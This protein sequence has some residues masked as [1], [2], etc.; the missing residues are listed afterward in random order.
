MKLAKANI[1]AW[2]RDNPGSPAY[3]SQAEAEAEA[4]KELVDVVSK[5]RS[6]ENYR[7]HHR[8]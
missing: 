5:G 3:T 2:F 1:R 4:V 6:L 8:F 7:K